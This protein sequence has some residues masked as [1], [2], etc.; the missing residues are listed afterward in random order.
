MLKRDNLN[1]IPWFRV[2]LFVFIFAAVSL[3]C[4]LPA[5]TF[6]SGVGQ[7]NLEGSLLES[8]LLN[9]TSPAIGVQFSISD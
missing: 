5:L 9:V 1:K 3:S 4:N 6:L 7:Q 8:G 2:T